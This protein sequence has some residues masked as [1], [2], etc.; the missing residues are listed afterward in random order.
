MLYNPETADNTTNDD[1]NDDGYDDDNDDD[2]DNDEEGVDNDSG[3]YT[4]LCNVKSKDT[5]IKAN[6]YW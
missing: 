3:G 5:I 6:I 4:I 1:D 2:D